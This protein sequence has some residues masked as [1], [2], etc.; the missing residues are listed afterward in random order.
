MKIVICETKQELGRLAAVTGAEAIRQALEEKDE[1]TIIVATGM[2]QFEMLAEL[3]AARDIA[4]E[5]VTVFHLDEYVGLS[6]S[7]PASF[8]RYLEERFVNQLPTP[9]R[10]FHAING[11]GDVAAE[12]RRLNG[13]IAGCEIAV[14]F[15]GIGENGHLAFND[16]PAD[17]ETEEPY[18]VVNLDEACR[19]Q[20]LGEG[21]FP[22]LEDVPQQAISMSIQQ[23]LKAK[24]IVCSAPDARKAKAIQ[25]AV[26]GPLTPQVPAS[27]LREHPRTFLYLDKASAALLKNLLEN[28]E[29]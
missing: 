22:T 17:F 20:Q 15:I 11:E 24:T 14:A 4:W 3:V 26:E 7:H 28:A 29:R 5:K 6:E 25:A 18:I 27:I 21:W 16:P 8:R 9:P 12:C 13:L 23:I 19:R 2:S 1:A 10:A